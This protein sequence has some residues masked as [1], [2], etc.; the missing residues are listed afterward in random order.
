MLNGRTVSFK[1]CVCVRICV[2]TATETLAWV[3]FGL[4]Y[5]NFMDFARIFFDLSYW[6]LIIMSFPFFPFALTGLFSYIYWS[7]IFSS[8]PSPLHKKESNSVCPEIPR[9]LINFCIISKYLQN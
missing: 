3:W 1:M 5:N 2:Y 6:G 7:C 8:S 9:S 4:T